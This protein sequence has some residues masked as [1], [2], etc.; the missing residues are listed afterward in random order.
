MGLAGAQE[1][2]GATACVLFVCTLWLA[3]CEKPLVEPLHLPV[4]DGSAQPHL[5]VAPDGEVVLSWL[6]RREQATTLYFS[7]LEADHWSD[8]V[9]V[10][11]GQNWFVNWADFPSVQ[12]IT[13]DLWAAHWLVKSA[14]PTFAYDVAV[15][16]SHDGGLRW[17]PPI[18]PHNDGTPTEHGFASLFALQ[19]QPALIWLDG[20]QMIE[21]HDG[22][23][24]GPMTLR[25]A[26][27][28][29]D[30]QVSGA[31][32][33]DDRVCD[34]CQTDVAVAAT[35][36]VAVYRNRSEHEIRDIYVSRMEQGIWQ[37]GRAVANDNWEISGCP[38]NGPAIDALGDQVA[39][40]WFTAA[41]GRSRVRMAWS[42]DAGVT[43]SNPYDIDIDRAIGRVDVALIS[44]TEAVVSWLRRGFSSQGEIVV[45]RVSSAGA[46]G[47][48]QVIAETT[49]G[50]PS[51]FPQMVR[52]GDD[53]IF[54]W[55]NTLAERV[56]TARL[57]IRRWEGR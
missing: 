28:N 36:P 5:A 23:A 32:L 11:S 3:G 40:A 15:S 2:R 46:L 44:D 45:R 56:Q 33:L 41:A 19:D 34:C 48:V 47:A 27:L 38:V 24:P 8:P 29:V 25:G 1:K 4:E 50:R 35:G 13:G 20:R 6:T 21:G 9:A 12:P 7:T 31:Q 39:V 18:T 57:A 51:G 16:L 37:A 26:R 54:A 10:A 52:S 53:L 14:E 22:A 43:F 55:T 17:A 42:V 30:Q 49:G